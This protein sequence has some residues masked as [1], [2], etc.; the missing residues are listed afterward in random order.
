[1]SAHLRRVRAGQQ[2]AGRAHGVDAVALTRAV[3][4]HVPGGVD[5][6]DLAAVAGQVTGQA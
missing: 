4:G 1:M 2:L 5:L 3:P 6:S